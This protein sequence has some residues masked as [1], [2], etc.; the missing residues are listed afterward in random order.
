MLV[1]EFVVDSP[2]RNFHNTIMLQISYL[3]SSARIASTVC[4]I[5]G[6]THEYSW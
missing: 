5:Y 4:S 1:A 2:Y 3:L 6:E